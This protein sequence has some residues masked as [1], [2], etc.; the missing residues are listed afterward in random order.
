M[1]FSKKKKDYFYLLEKH[2]ESGAYTICACGEDCPSEKDIKEFEK[3]IGYKLPDDF[4]DFSFS[5]LGGIY[6]EVKEEIWPRAKQ[7]D[8][9]PFWS[10]LYGLYVYGFADDIPEWM[11][12][13]KAVDDFRAETESNYTP[14]MKIVGDADIY[15]FGEDKKIY[16]WSHETFELEH[17]DK[18]FLDLLDYELSE[19][20]DRKEKKKAQ[21]RK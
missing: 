16:R 11:D 18:S 20:E 12:I 19:L 21:L 1:F 9:G 6:V 2:L 14:F 5:T 13:R 3:Q 8:V 4:R 15:C 7:Y 17:I 10:F